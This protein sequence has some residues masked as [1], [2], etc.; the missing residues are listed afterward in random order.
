[1]RERRKLFLFFFIVVYRLIWFHFVFGYLTSDELD[2]HCW[3]HL[4]CSGW[5]WRCSSSCCWWDC[6]CLKDA[7]SRLVSSNSDF[8]VFYSFTSPFFD[9]LIAAQKCLREFDGEIGW[10]LGLLEHFSLDKTLNFTMRIV[11]TWIT[12]EFEWIWAHSLEM[13]TDWEFFLFNGASVCGKYW[14]YCRAPSAGVDF[15]NYCNGCL[16][17]DLS[18]EKNL[19]WWYHINRRFEWVSYVRRIKWGCCYLQSL[20]GQHIL[21][22]I[23][24][25]TKSQVKSSLKMYRTSIKFYTIDRLIDVFS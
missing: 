21:P 10:N 22:L 13:F 23:G 15:W 14:N 4:D 19:R 25:H 17:R 16:K 20:I 5:D 6:S 12:C 1:M 7:G 2:C 3:P 18:Y 9:V 11:G 24:T 8:F